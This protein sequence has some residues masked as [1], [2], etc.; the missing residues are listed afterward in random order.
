[1]R[2]L[3]F[4]PVWKKRLRKEGGREGRREGALRVD[5]VGYDRVVVNTMV[6]AVLVGRWGDR[7]LDL[8]GRG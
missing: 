7:G 5:E 4:I 8:I 2:G 1:M 3:S 6:S